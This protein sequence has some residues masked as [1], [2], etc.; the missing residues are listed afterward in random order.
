MTDGGR[1]GRDG[2]EKFEN[3]LKQRQNRRGTKGMDHAGWRGPLHVYLAVLAA[4]ATR[5]SSSSLPVSIPP[6]VAHP[7]SYRLFF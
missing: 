4:V 3:S 1:R 6:A 7:R 2:G 5:R